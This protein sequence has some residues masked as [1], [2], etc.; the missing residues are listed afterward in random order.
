MRRLA[1]ETPVTYVIFDLLWLDGHS[2]MDLP[3]TERRARLAEL[4]LTATAGACPTTSSATAPLLAATEQQGL[5]GVIAKRLDSTYQPGRRTPS[6]LKIKNVDRQEV[7]VGGWVPGDGKRRDR[8]GA[9]LV[10]VREDGDLRHVGRVGTGFTEAELDRLAE[11]LRPLEREDSPFA[12]AARPDPARRRVRRSR[13]RGRGR[14]PRVDRRRPAA[15]ALLQGPARRQAGRAGRAQRPTDRRLARVREGRPRRGRRRAPGQALEPRQGPLSRGRLRQARRHRLLRAHRAGRPAAPQGPRADAQALPQRRRRPVLLREERA[16][17]P[18]RLGADRA[19]AGCDRLRRLRR[20]PTLVWLANLADLELHTSLA[21]ADD[22][23]A[24][25]SRLRPRS[26]PAGDGRRVL[27]RR[28]AARGMFEGL[29]LECFAK[30][31]GSKGM[32]VYL[33]LNSE[34]TFAQT[35]AF[36]KAVAELLAREEPG[37]V[38]ARQTKPRARARCSSTGARTTSTRRRST[39]TRCARWRA[40]RCRRRSPG[41]RSARRGRRA[42]GLTFE[43]ADVR[44][45]STSTATSSRRC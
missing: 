2:L 26:R 32:Q 23:G 13:A 21:L 9:L 30:T 25:R 31:S 12:P 28:G 34:A 38:V 42:R 39:S 41:T 44:A 43:A 1:K 35:K 5:E 24:R 10:G 19:R 7:V 22:P 18:A 4:E 17:A 11:M 29:G 20:Q 14:V 8:I 40:R 45:A 16:V 33:P 36:S 3:Y 15:R 37:L 6:W 27:P